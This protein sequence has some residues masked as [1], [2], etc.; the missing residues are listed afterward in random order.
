M[1][2][3]LTILVKAVWIRLFNSETAVMV[4]VCLAGD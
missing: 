4:K 1:Q 2:V 3:L